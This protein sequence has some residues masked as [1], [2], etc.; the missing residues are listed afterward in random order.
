MHMNANL[1]YNKFK[2]LLH[3]QKE[4]ILDVEQDNA[5]STEIVELDQAK[6]GRL[7]RMEALQD[8]AMAIETEHRRRLQL[9]KIDAAF[10]RIEEEDYGYCLRCGEAINEQRLMIDPCATLCINCAAAAEE[11]H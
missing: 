4:T 10:H 11:H 2:R 9:Q 8:Q 7:S 6:I 1:D 5:Q 3:E